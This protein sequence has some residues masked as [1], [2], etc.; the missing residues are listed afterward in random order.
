VAV[1]EKTL[2]RWSNGDVT[3]IRSANLKKLADALECQVQDLIELSEVDAYS[4]EKNRD[5]LVSELTNDS[6]LYQLLA[7]SKIRLAISL[8]KSTFHSKLSSDIVANFLIKLGY[9]SLILRKQKSAKKHFTKALNKAQVAGSYTQEFSAHLGV[10]LTL[11]FNSD[12]KK[13]EHILDSCQDLIEYSGK[14]LAHYYNTRALFHLSMGHFDEAISFANDC[15]DACAPDKISIEKKLFLSASWHLKGASYLFLGQLPEAK[16]CC[17]KSITE[18]K[19]SGYNRSIAASQSYL[20]AVEACSGDIESAI[21]LVE[22]SIK[23]IGKNDI[24][25]PS[26]LC[27]AIFVFRLSNDHQR[28]KSLAKDLVQISKEQTLTLAFADYQFYLFEKNQGNTLQAI[29][30]LQKVKNRLNSLGV[31]TWDSWLEL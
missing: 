5:V 16:A 27:I 19:L 14:E 2:T 17:V 7:S 11:Y 6:L 18:A 23:L 3:R 31:N 12:L 15:Y 13:C 21:S 26:I 30:E 22:D 9:A 20:A 4:S 1:S 10:A 24:S 28:M 8:I 25:L 29:Q